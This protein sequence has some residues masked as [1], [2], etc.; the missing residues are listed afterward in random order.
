MWQKKAEYGYS[1]HGYSKTF[2]FF[3]SIQ[4]TYTL[5]TI[6]IY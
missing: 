1:G 6:I 5:E 3:V 4:T 2:N